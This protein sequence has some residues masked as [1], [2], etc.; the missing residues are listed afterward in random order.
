MIF[1]SWLGIALVLHVGI[2]PTLLSQLFYMRGVELIGPQRT[3]LFYNFVPVTGALMAVAVLGEPFAW[4][5]ATGFVLVL[6]A[7]VLAE[8]WRARQI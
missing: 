4:Y 8:R 7:I 6:M 1:P 3:G 2:F 5:H